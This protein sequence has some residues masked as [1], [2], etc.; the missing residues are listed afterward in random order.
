MTDTNAP[1]NQSDET[2][3]ATL[4]GSEPAETIELT[5]ISGQ[6]QKSFVRPTAGESGDD[7]EEVVWELDLESEGYVYRRAGVPGADYS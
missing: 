4:A 5:F 6:P 3:T 1:E 7:S 2:Y